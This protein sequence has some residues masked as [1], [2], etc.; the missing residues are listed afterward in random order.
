[1]YR[2]TVRYHVMSRNLTSCRVVSYNLLFRYIMWCRVISCRVRH[3]VHDDPNVPYEMMAVIKKIVDDSTGKNVTYCYV[4]LSFII[5]DLCHS[6]HY[7][8]RQLPIQ[9]TPVLSSLS[10][11]LSLSYSLSHPLFLSFSYIFFQFLRSCPPSLRISYA[12]LPA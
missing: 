5:S 4:F 2:D 3:L 10:P 6:T 1:M 7:S 8:F 11:F 12:A 9:P